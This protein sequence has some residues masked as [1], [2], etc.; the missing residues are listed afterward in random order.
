MAK[1]QQRQGQG[2]R[3]MKTITKRVCPQTYR[4]LGIA[5]DGDFDQKTVKRVTPDRLAFTPIMPNGVKVTKPTKVYLGV[6][7]G[8]DVYK[9]DRFDIERW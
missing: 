4:V 5:V 1:R 9:V 7:G 8:R 2:A 6:D 3:L